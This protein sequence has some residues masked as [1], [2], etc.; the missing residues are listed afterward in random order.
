MERQREQ[1]NGERDEDLREIDIQ[2][3]LASDLRLQT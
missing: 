3:C 1:Q 2:Q